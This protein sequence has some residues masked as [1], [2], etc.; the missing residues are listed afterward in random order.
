[1]SPPIHASAFAHKGAGCLILGDSGSGKS[2]LLAEVMLRGAKL[3]A[4]DRVALHASDG[5]LIANPVEP[6]KGVV[7]LR[8]F[9]LIRQE[10]VVEAQA[11]HLVIALDAAANERLPEPATHT[12]FGVNVPFLS[13][14]PPPVLSAA[15]LLIYLEAVQEGRTLPT[16]WH[17]LG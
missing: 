11:I 5:K 4:D 6:L 2:T 9:G 15:S 12:Y 3:V 10:E 13:V 1:M 14:P 7:E 8:G 17:P 16:D